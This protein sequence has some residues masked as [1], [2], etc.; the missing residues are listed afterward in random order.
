MSAEGEK[1]I[2]CAGATDKIA[3]TVTLCESLDGHILPFQVI[4]S[5]KTPKSLPNVNF[6]PGFCLA[7]NEK[8]WSSEA[9]TMRLI[10]NVLIP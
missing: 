9:E 7:Y 5:G 3:I 1:H 4:Y 8:H 2:S 10:K 6:F